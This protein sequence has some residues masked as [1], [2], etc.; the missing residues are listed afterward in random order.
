MELHF[1]KNL[2]DNYIA[3]LFRPWIDD[4][5]G[6]LDFAQWTRKQMLKDN[7]NWIIRINASSVSETVD[8][9]INT[10]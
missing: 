9:Y 5:V 7:K 10:Q 8:C 2:S 6:T 1:S 3:V 4:D